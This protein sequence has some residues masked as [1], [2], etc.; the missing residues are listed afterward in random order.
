MSGTYDPW[1]VVNQVMLA[2]AREGLHPRMTGADIG[3][4]KEA[5][6]ALLIAIQVQPVVPD[7]AALDA[8]EAAEQ[9]SQAD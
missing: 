7:Y 2:L 9:A 1:A 6:E 8:A 5:A 4:A 3:A